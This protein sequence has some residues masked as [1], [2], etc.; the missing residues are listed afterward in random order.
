MTKTPSLNVRIEALRKEYETL[1]PGKE[2]LLVVLEEA[3]IA[4]SVY[5]S[6]AIENSTLTLKETETILTEGTIPRTVTLREVHEAQ[7][8]AKVSEVLRSAAP[9]GMT[10]EAIL[11]LHR[12]LLTGIDDPIA[13][14][15]RSSGEYVRVGT[16][17]APGPERIERMLGNALAEYGS[18]LRHTAV[19]KIAKLHLAFELIHPFNDGNGRIGRVLVNWQLRELWFPPVI[20]RN[21]EKN[22]YYTALREYQYTKEE[23]PMER[24]LSLAIMESLH[25]RIAHL[26]GESIVPLSE[27]VRRKKKAA[28]AVFNAA[29]RQTLGA[30][31]ERNKWMIGEPGRK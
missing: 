9:K 25:K 6:N 23:K 8:L 3:E 16:H 29:R 31:R 30:F 27:Y 11:D 20:I 10:Q 15:F 5:N 18:D 2:R 4:E 1:R 17:I 22:A 24:I 7:N 13:G 12:M 28:P 26:K 14:R 19:R 21:K